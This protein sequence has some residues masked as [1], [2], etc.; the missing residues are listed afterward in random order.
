MAIDTGGQRSGGSPQQT[1]D[2]LHT[3][4]PFALPNGLDAPACLAK[5]RRVYGIAFNVTVN[6]P[7]PVGPVGGRHP[8]AFA[9]V[10]MPQAPMD[11]HDQATARK[12]DVGLSGQF[13]GVKPV[14]KAR[15]VKPPPNVHLCGG[16][17]GVNAAH[18]AAAFTLGNIVCH[19]PGA[20]SSFSVSPPCPDG[21]GPPASANRC[22]AR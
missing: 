10:P 8:R 6:L 5:R 3:R 13:R 9:A 1:Q 19:S 21:S 4:L 16:V 15:G 22:P 2:S 20:S 11:E 18:D 17:F 7:F 12:H 14:T